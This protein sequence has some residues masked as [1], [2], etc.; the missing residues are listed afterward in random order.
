MERITIIDDTFIYEDKIQFF[1]MEAFQTMDDFEN[2]L[3]TKEAEGYNKCFFHK[4]FNTKDGEP[5]MVKGVN[6][7]LVMFK[8]FK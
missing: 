2:Y 4:A 8:L 6:V 7:Y 1:E 5:V 3:I